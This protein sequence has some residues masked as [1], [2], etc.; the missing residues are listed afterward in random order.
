MIS[1]SNKEH[2]GYKPLPGS[3][4]IY[5]KGSIYKDMRVPVREIA[6]MPSRTENNVEIPNKSI[7]V[8][9]TSG[10]YTDPNNRVDMTKGLPALKGLIRVPR[11]ALLTLPQTPQALLG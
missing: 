9:D 1:P 2:I 7:E 10:P 4:K 6:L 11:P 8:Y 5:K 3:R